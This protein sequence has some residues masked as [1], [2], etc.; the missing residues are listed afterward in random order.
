MTINLVDYRYLGRLGDFKN[1]MPNKKTNHNPKED[2]GCVPGLFLK[3][4]HR[5]IKVSSN[6]ISPNMRFIINNRT[7]K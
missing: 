5:N 2:L 1:S 7:M 3:R 4:Y 6:S